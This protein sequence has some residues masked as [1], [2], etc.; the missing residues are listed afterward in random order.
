MKAINLG[1]IGATGMVGRKLLDLLAKRDFPINKLSLFGKSTVGESVLFS[2][3]EQIIKPL[4]K[5]SFNGLDLT[6]FSAGSSVAKEFCYEAINQDNYVIDLSSEFRYQEDVPLIVPEINGEIIDDLKQPTLIANPNCTTAQL[7]MVL[8]PIHDLAQ[9]DHFDLE[10]FSKESPDIQ[11]VYPKQIAFNAIPQCDIFLDDYY[12]KEEMKV[13]WETQKIMD[14]KIT[15]NATCVRVPVFNGHSEAV[16]IKTKNFVN[17]EEVLK[18]LNNFNG[19]TVID[20][21][22]LQ[23]YP[24]PIEH[25]NDTEEV[26]VGRV[27]SKDMH[28]HG[29]ISLWIVA[30]NVYGKGAALNAI[31]IAERLLN[32]NSLK[33]N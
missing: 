18:A 8:K 30:D 3:E 4:N 22:D 26:Y 24:T 19:V 23:E 17:R 11:K 7:L 9:I 32:N 21:P 33:K 31:Q 6:I 15:V 25:A 13:V 5:D 29:L 12:T 20:N 27:R 14:P 28:D 10:T 1:I 2:S 16:F